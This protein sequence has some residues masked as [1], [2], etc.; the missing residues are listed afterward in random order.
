M[1]KM[2][3]EY[4]LFE[5]FFDA[6]AQDQ[7]YLTQR[8]LT[9][10]LLRVLDMLLNLAFSVKK[11][12]LSPLS[13]R[14][15]VITAAECQSALSNRM[16]WKESV[17]SGS[18]REAM[19]KTRAYFVGRLKAAGSAALPFPAGTGR[20]GLTEPE[21]LCLILALSVRLDRKYERLYSCLQDC[22]Q[23]TAPTLG[24]SLSLYTLAGGADWE[25]AR[26]AVGG[27]A[28]WMLF[29]NGAG[30]E[31]SF[32]APDLSLPLL[33]PEEAADCLLTKGPWNAPEEETQE[34][35]FRKD[36]VEEMIRLW[37]EERGALIC[38]YGQWGI[39]RKFL[40]SHAARR[41]GRS[42]VLWR[43]QAR[44][45]QD[46]RAFAGRL[47]GKCAA[48]VMKDA[49]LCLELSGALSEDGGSFFCTLLSYVS[50]HC[51]RI[52]VLT[53]QKETGFAGMDCPYYE[54]GLAPLSFAEKCGMWEKQASCY[55]QA[56]GLDLKSFAGQYM[57]SAGEIGLVM[58]T[59]AL[60]ASAKGRSRIESG[61]VAAAVGSRA[62]GRMGN[63]AV[64]LTSA[65][66]WEDLVLEERQKRLLR[67][68]CGRA[69]LKGTVEEEWGFYEKTSYGKGL[70]ML[71]YGEPGTGKTLAAQI[72]ANELGMDL[73]R[74]DLSQTVSK[75]IGETQKNI[76]GIFS[77]AKELNAV[78][79]FDEA[80]ALF[81]RR[82][83]V[84]DSNDRNANAETAHLLQ[85]M[86]AYEGITI[87][88]TNY[89]GNID[90]AFKRR[91][92]YMI[93]F[94]FPSEEERLKLWQRSLPERAKTEETL[95]LKLL[96]AKLE[97][98]GS[99]ISEIMVQAAYIAAE[100]GRGIKNRDLLEAVKIYCEKQ[101]LMMPELEL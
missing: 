73:Y 31:G 68:A 21:K 38:L 90:E 79:F 2:E 98:S 71:F 101:N 50:K 76:S 49:V 7:P 67:H 25:Q 55:P 75:Y 91:I 97:L 27:W 14:G 22:A 78:L 6:R 77:R 94:H 52:A 57:L 32:A 89:V 41:T 15:L 48:A 10:D 99:A 28:F 37:R 20:L 95:E 33:L 56:C 86:E 84:R 29:E 39:G 85:Q 58:K 47:R 30:D 46:E 40:V 26:E 42:V 72:V 83:Q 88:A 82:S 17:L 34:L 9:E 35:L 60:R 18:V 8:E 45:M 92:K 62:G 100:E 5:S 53:E 12:E 65:W 11:E 74:V 64:R 1:V 87:L 13:M 81:A 4:G 96:A 19:E 24:L 63:A 3:E 43:T 66:G 54:I 93:R 23:E 36:T 61:D 44:A 70:S 69:R 51:P 59:A 80:D 16:Y